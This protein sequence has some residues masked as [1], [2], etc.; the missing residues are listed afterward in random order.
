[1]FNKNLYIDKKVY[2]LIVVKVYIVNYVFNE[3]LG[4][5][6]LFRYKSNLLY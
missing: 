5:G 1:M 4:I 2:I 3:V 6:E